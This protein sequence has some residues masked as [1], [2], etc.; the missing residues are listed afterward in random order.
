MAIDSEAISPRNHKDICKGTFIGHL[1]FYTLR[2]GGAHKALLA[3]VMLDRAIYVM[4]NLQ[5][6]S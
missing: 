6:M 2:T 4:F 5:I 3:C 1:N